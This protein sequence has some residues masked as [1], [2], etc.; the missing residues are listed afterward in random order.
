MNP[1][2]Y[3]QY[4]QQYIQPQPMQ[5]LPQHMEPR[6]VTYTVD[7]AEQMS[8]I[9]PLPN[10]IYLGVNVRS[11]KIFLRRINNDGQIETKTFSV[12]GEQTKKPDMQEV[13]ARLETI[14]KK[15]SEGERHESDDNH[16]A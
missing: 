2:T 5:Q 16:I 14:E 15:L 1:Y 10:T 6:V 8:G 9:T 3:N 4:P 13:L 12:V 7:T 11:D